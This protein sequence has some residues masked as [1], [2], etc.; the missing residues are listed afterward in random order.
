M[1]KP[2]AGYG[3]NAFP[4]TSVGVS[5]QPPAGY[6]GNFP[7]TPPRATTPDEGRFNRAPGTLQFMEQSSKLPEYLDNQTLAYMQQQGLATAQLAQFY[8]FD[9]KTGTYQ[10]NQN[11]QTVNKNAGAAGQLQ[12]GTYID[13]GTGEVKRGT[14]P[15]GTDAA[16]QR[17]DA[18][19][20]VWD[21]KT[22]TRDIYGGK[23]IQVGEKRWERN[24]RGKLV[25]V[26]YGKGGK[27]KVVS[28]GGHN[29][30]E[31]A[32]PEPAPTPKIPG[33]Q[34]AST[35]FNVASG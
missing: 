21:P 1:N 35:N 13:P 14:T 20:N 17:L 19:G 24:N 12:P 15:F 32:A 16:G 23:F 26:Q 18:S 4:K 31:E 8:T 22:A 3:P 25:K 7:T 2:P 28:G 6:G 33:M 29:T 34:S 10:L 11:G 27:K 30:V 9:A 5:Q